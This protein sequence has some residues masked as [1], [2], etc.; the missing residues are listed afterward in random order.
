[1][2]FMEFFKQYK[3]RIIAVAFGILFT[4]LCFTINFWRTLLLFAIVGAAYFI[5]LLLDQGGR[6]RVAEYFRT[7]FHKS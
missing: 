4:V 5:G 7:L 1:M 3:W 2:N 6:E